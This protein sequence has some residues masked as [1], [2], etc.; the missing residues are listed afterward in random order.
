MN[1]SDGYVM[2]EAINN[3]K[4]KHVLILYWERGKEVDTSYSLNVSQWSKCQGQ[5]SGQVWRALRVWG[6][7][8][9]YTMHCLFYKYFIIMNKGAGITV[10]QDYQYNWVHAQ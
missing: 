10:K 8:T 1:L 9:I 3:S 7:P 6:I 2:P 5:L 4:L